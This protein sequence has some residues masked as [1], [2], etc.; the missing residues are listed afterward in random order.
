MAQDEVLIGTLT[1]R[2]TLVYAARLRLRGGAGVPSP[3]EVADGVIAE[4]G[5]TDARNTVIG[6]WHM[7]GVSG[8]QRRRVVIGCELVISPTLLFLDE[9][10]SGATLVFLSML[11]RTLLTR[12]DA[13]ID[14][15]GLDAAAAFHVTGV[16]KRLCASGGR[17]KTGRTVLCVIHQPASE[18]R[19]AARRSVSSVRMRVCCMCAA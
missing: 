9:P 12:G 6:N 18:A 5:L 11:H 17:C 8:G 16:I 4:L 14:A 13:R 1:V 2:E 19:R 3:A 10:T 7:R 15:A